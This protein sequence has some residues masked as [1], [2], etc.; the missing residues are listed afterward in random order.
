MAMGGDASGLLNGLCQASTERSQVLLL[1]PNQ[2]ECSYGF[3]NGLAD[4]DQTAIHPVPAHREDEPM[5]DQETEQLGIEFGFNAF[6]LPSPGFIQ[7]ALILPQLKDQLN[8]PAQAHQH[9]NLLGGG[10]LLRDRGQHEVPDG[11]GERLLR[12]L[13]TMFAR[14]SA[15]TLAFAFDAFWGEGDGNQAIPAPL[16]GD[17]PICTVA[18]MLAQPVQYIQAAS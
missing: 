13:T 2:V 6:G 10:Y 1:L 14:G 15:N 18:R 5:L 16:P 3:T 12:G 9:G 7:L 11:Q 8:L 4:F 17:A